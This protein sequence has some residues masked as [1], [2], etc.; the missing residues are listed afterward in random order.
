MLDKF[1]KNPDTRRN[2]NLNCL[3]KMKEF[4]NLPQKNPGPNISNS[5][6]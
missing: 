3:I 1:L 5:D 2:R 6:F 4:K